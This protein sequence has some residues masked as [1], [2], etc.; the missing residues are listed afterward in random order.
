MKA[1]FESRLRR[2]GSTAQ[3]APGMPSVTARYVPRGRTARLR[4]ARR[5]VTTAAVPAS[6]TL[7]ALPRFLDQRLDEGLDLLALDGIA[8]AR[9]ARRS[10]DGHAA[11]LT[12]IALVLLAP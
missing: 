1:I 7:R 6:A 3:T 12:Q 11:S 9:R 10:G 8:R 5:A 2:E 4:R